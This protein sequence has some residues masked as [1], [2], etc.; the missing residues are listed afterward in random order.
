MAGAVTSLY[1][2]FPCKESSRAQAL[3]PRIYDTISCFTRFGSAVGLY[4]RISTLV[5]VVVSGHSSTQDV[6]TPKDNILPAHSA[7]SD[8]R[9]PA[10]L[11]T[12]IRVALF[13]LVAG[14]QAAHPNIKPFLHF[15]NNSQ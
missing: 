9:S 13:V 10:L 1:R 8:K 12:N 3:F 14:S 11:F 2:V 7:V 5:A 4:R 6:E 15:P